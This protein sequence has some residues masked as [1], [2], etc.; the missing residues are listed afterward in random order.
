MARG[1]IRDA[2]DVPTC[3]GDTSRGSTGPSP[4]RASSLLVPESWQSCGVVAEMWGQT[5]R[6]FVSPSTPKHS[7][8]PWL[9]PVTLTLQVP[10]AQSGLGHGGHKLP[11]KAFRLEVSKLLQSLGLFVLLPF[12]PAHRMGGVWGTS[13]SPTLSHPAVRGWRRSDLLGTVHI[14]FPG[15]VP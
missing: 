15:D 1:D 3:R 13:A 12:A 14:S 7:V 4:P 6:P 10:M 9:A 5:R 2:A 8:T 11:G